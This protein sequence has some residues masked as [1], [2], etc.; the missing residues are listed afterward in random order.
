MVN[1]I[2]FCEP[3]TMLLRPCR[4]SP[5]L[6]TVVGIYLIWDTCIVQHFERLQ[7]KLCPTKTDPEDSNLLDCEKAMRALAKRSNGLATP[8]GIMMKATA[9][10]AWPVSFVWAWGTD[11]LRQ[12]SACTVYDTGACSLKCQMSDSAQLTADAMPAGKQPSKAM[13]PKQ[14]SATS[15]LGHAMVKDSLPL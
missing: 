7:A 13:L 9:W 6:Q 4:S 10:V 12:V 1:E 2:Y 15:P 14:C 3:T 11:K 8:P 5:T